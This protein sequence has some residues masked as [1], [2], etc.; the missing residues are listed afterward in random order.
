MHRGRYCV[1]RDLSTE[2]SACA[3]VASIAMAATV[4]KSFFIFISGFAAAPV[5]F[6]IV[7]MVVS[8]DVLCPWW[9]ECHLQW[10]EGSFHLSLQWGCERFPR[11]QRSVT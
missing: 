6:E 9:F 7:F 4:I 3:P 8:L 2:V 5:I 10:A 11:I 1:G